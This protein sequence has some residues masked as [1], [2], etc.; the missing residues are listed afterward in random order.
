MMGVVYRARQAGVARD[1]A[2][3]VLRRKH[4]GTTASRRFE[5]EAEIISRLK[6]PHTVQLFD[7]GTTKD[8]DMYIVTDFLHGA[9][10]GAVLDSSRLSLVRTLAIGEQICASLEEAHALGVVH[11]DLKP[12]NVFVL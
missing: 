9:T 3:Q 11:R 5:R 4:W 8:G 1:L 7:R 2:V 12:D 10:L 6:N